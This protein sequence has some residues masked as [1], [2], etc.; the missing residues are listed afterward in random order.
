MLKDCRVQNTL[1]VADLARARIFYEK[2]LGLS[3]AL[4]LPTGVFYACGAGTRFAVSNSAGVASGA[5]TQMAF[6]VDDILTEVRELRS[7]GVV[8][9]EYELPGLKTVDGIADQGTLKAA[10]FKDTEGNLLAIMEPSQPI[11]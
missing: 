11:D 5:H 9:E 2:E 7:Q 4:E 6:V 3:A 10:C 8:F 1:P